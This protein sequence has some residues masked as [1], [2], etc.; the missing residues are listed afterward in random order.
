MVRGRGLGGRPRSVGVIGWL[1]LACCVVPGIAGAQELQRVTFEEAVRR[2]ITSHPTVQQA[3]ADIMRAEALL[4][5]SRARA[6]P[7]V[8]ATF[9]TTI[10]DPVTSFAGSSIV[11]RTQT[12]TTAAVRVP[13]FAPVT[14]AERQQ[15]QDQVRVSQANAED[16]RRAVAVQAARA[17]LAI[18]AQRRVLELNAR[19]RDTARQHYDFARERFEGGL[20]SRLNALRAQQEW[21]SDEARVEEASLALRRAQEALGVLVAS[22]A[23]VDAA[24]EPVIE[25]APADG[26]AALAERRT[27]L[28]AIIAR[29]AAAQRFAEDA[30]KANLPSAA[31]EVTPQYLAPSGLFANSRSWR[32]A[33]VLNV[34]IF[35]SGGRRAVARERAALVDAVRAERSNAER[36]AAS[37]VRIAAEAVRAGERALEHA[38]EAAMQAGE[39]MQITDVAFREGA[40]TNIELIDAQRRARDADTAAAVAEDTLRQARLEALIANGLFPAP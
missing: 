29:E 21:Q 23:P 36:Q 31:A 28:R 2:A 19:A 26:T 22:D 16:A 32:A 25:S 20:G 18:I 10:V 30:S 3:A 38:R 8:D 5:Q 14:W 27:D 34:P 15:S 7:S 4:Q 13:L 39:V 6:L 24:G 17:Y 37:E 12:L 33:V 1:T 40:T 11:P 9:T 35:D